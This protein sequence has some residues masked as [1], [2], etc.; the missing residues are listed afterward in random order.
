MLCDKST[1]VPRRYLSLTAK[2]ESIIFFASLF[3]AAL[4]VV[5]LRAPRQAR[6]QQTASPAVST[7]ANQPVAQR[8]APP[9]FDFTYIPAETLAAAAFQ[10]GALLRAEQWQPLVP[11]A[12]QLLQ[13]TM[14]GFSIADFHQVTYAFHGASGMPAQI[15]PSLRIVFQVN[16]SVNLRERLT[17]PLFG[18]T[19]DA[20]NGKIFYRG[21]GPNAT[22]G[23]DAIAWRQGYVVLGDDTIV[24]DQ[25]GAL[26]KLLANPSARRT[27]AANAPGQIYAFVDTA[28]LK[29]AVGFLLYSHVYG[30]VAPLLINTQEF[31][32]TVDLRNPV[33]LNLTA[34]CT[35]ADSTEIVGKTMEAVLTLGKN[36]LR[37]QLQFFS[38]Q[39]AR[40]PQG[41]AALMQQ[42]LRIGNELLADSNVHFTRDERNV[43][44]KVSA[45]FELS[46]AIKDLVP[47]LEAAR[48]ASHSNKSADNLKQIAMAILSYESARRRLPAAA[49][50]G[51][52]GLT[53]HSWR[54]EILPLLGYQELYERYRLNEPWDSEH[55]RALIKEMP[56][57][58]RHPLD[59]PASTNTSYF[60]FT[61]PDA[62]FFNNQGTRLAQIPDGTS[63]TILAVEAARGV[64]WTK[65]EDFSYAADQPLPKLGGW[66]AN[67]AFAYAHC[68]GSVL[69]EQNAADEN[70]L[71]AKITRNGREVVPR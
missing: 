35:T 46:V 42:W 12:N 15:G 43:V 48:V 26:R 20:A 51:P 41:E 6:A 28:A 21:A 10:P 13:E 9:Q 7:P 5:G 66:L 19:A 52:D 32:G 22:V 44:L 38:E 27:V 53:P 60:V 47:A 3:A 25:V 70:R 29:P 69:V 18:Y 4:S 39:G 2:A 62:M 1:I 14:P 11:A 40:L 37:Q 68:D 16:A 24:I 34:E 59:D 50:L 33:S 23:P 31:R 58:Y 71:R 56:T 61:G 36:V 54:V 57:V 8:D 30:S 64:P 17:K 49:P 65:P 55:N 63:N 45:P 67:G